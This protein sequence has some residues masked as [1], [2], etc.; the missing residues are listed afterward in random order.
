MR[1]V[2]DRNSE[3]EV[4]NDLG[5]TCLA[6]GSADQ[7]VA[8][9]ESALALAREVHVRPQEARAHNGIAHALCSTDPPAARDHWRRAL[10]IYLEIGVPEA[11]DIRRRLE[12]LDG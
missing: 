12:D 11:D 1:K 4:L 6:M 2:G 5:E 3:S 7:A 9:H 8:H 10:D